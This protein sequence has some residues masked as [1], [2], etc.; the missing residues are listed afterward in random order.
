MVQ[1]RLHIALDKSGRRQTLSQIALVIVMIV[2]M[3][4]LH[5]MFCSA[6]EDIITSADAFDA[7]VQ[8][9]MAR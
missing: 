5:V 8:K 2:H 3:P 1:H 9:A 7:V 6:A 4:A